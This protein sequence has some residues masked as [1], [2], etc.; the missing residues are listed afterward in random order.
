MIRRPP[1][2][3]ARRRLAL[4]GAA[5]LIALVAGFVV[6]A[7]GG[8]APASRSAGAPSKQAVEH[9]ASLP[10]TRQIGELLMISFRGPGLPG[11]VK[12]VLRE[13]R[14][15]GVILFA[16]NARTPQAMRALTRSLER[17]GRGRVLI[18]VDQEGG[19]VRILPW[20]HPTAAQSAQATAAAAR[21]QARRAGADL[22]A[23]G[24]NITL[25]PV[26]D[27]AE[28][29]SVMRGRAFPGGTAQVALTTAA[30]VAGYRG[31]G[32]AATLKHFPGLGAAGANTDD[33]A[34]TISS[35]R[36]AL[37]SR[38]LPPFR[39]GIAAGAQLVMAS[40]ALYPALDPRNIA[41]QS[42]AILNDLLRRRLGFGGVVVTD[43]M[44]AAAVVRR[45]SI[46]TAALRSLAAGAD[47][48][49]MTGPRS[50]PRVSREL[51]IAAARSPKLRAR[52]AESAARVIAL[53]RSLKLG[54][55]PR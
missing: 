55:S 37:A 9:A 22:A 36:A 53:K 49:L 18:A 45:S 44:E 30:A 34:V 23:A 38:D 15:G 14:A 21:D 40:H 12:R 16:G 29:E 54:R 43:S 4:L 32:I 6:G 20:A 46:E 25:A 2:G 10:V 47:L 31:T 48:L 24:V 28:S 33:T 7:S 26:A 19:P 41:S 1:P 8:G 13:G 51:A 11:D 3:P 52:I 27:V 35:P 50:F 39:A 17:A 5:A 42:P